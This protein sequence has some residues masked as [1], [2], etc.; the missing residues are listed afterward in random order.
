M[1]YLD[2]FLHQRHPKGL[3]APKGGPAKTD[4]TRR[5]RRKTI[6]KTDTLS[7]FSRA[8]R[9]DEERNIHDKLYK[10]G[11]DHDENGDLAPKFAPGETVLRV[12]DPDFLFGDF[13]RC[14]IC[15]D[16]ADIVLR[17]A[18]AINGHQRFCAPCLRG[19][20][21]SHKAFGKRDKRKARNCPLCG[22]KWDQ[23]ESA[24]GVCTTRNKRDIAHCLKYRFLLRELD[25]DD[26]ARPYVTTGPYC[27]WP[28]GEPDFA[29]RQ[30]PRPETEQERAEIDRLAAMD[31]DDGND[32][33]G[34]ARPVTA[35]PHP[36]PKESNLHGLPAETRSNL[37]E[38]FTQMTDLT[39]LSRFGVIYADPPWSYRDL[40]HSRHIDRQYPIMRVRD[41]AALPV[42]DIS[43]SDEK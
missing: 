16:P 14:D 17:R 34:A 40:G 20:D 19:Q 7:D 39:M 35:E 30:D 8:A 23:S 38:S 10:R 21:H 42:Q 1:N 5:Q 12:L 2:D 22:G 26:L 4:K 9:L 31:A 13:G 33:N 28:Q 24:D 18:A 25:A 37:M 27:P 3:Y 29:I 11:Y 15:G 36:K 41:L 32:I 43:L 6:A